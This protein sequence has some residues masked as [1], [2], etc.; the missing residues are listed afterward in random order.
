MM[1]NNEKVK[2][3][4][5]LDMDSLLIMLEPVHVSSG[6]LVG[7]IQFECACWWLNCKPFG[8][9]PTL[10]QTQAT[11]DVRRNSCA[12]RLRELLQ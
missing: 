2:E 5:E 4:M 12:T 8:I 11:I 3:G 7:L 9:P 1:V 10:S 6:S